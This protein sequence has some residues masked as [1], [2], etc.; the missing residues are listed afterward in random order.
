MDCQ[1]FLNRYS[2]Y[3]DSLL[4]RSELAV[5]RAH[6]GSCPSCARYDR[7]LRKGRMLARQLPPVR[8]TDDFLPRLHQRVHPLRR[9]RRGETAAPIL[10]GAAAALA[11]VTVLATAFWALSLMDQPAAPAIAA[12]GEDPPGADAVTWTVPPGGGWSIAGRTMSPAE[13]PRTTGWSAAGVDPHV[14]S[15][16]SPL[17]TGPPAYRLS[18]AF[19]R[20]AS[21]SALQTLD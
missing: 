17:V 12:D 8:P 7:V 11:G 19:P 21:T 10:G 4:S 2:D 16:Y 14:A 3:D 18:G 13:A 6:L 1:D 15:S 9:S 20:N 5:F